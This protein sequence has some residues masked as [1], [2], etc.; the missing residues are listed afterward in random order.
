MGS[1]PFDVSARRCCRRRVPR[2]PC[3]GAAT[4]GLGLTLEE[5]MEDLVP[6]WGEGTVVA[7]GGDGR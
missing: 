1:D 3:D 2:T 4:T 6:G 7:M 5:L